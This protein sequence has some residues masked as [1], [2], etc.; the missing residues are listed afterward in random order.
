MRFAMSSVMGVARGEVGRVLVLVLVVGLR[1][2]YGCLR[3]RL[4]RTIPGD[5]NETLG[6][7][8]AF[9]ADAM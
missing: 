6:G 7:R 3:G 4:W 5:G 2:T 8:V 1:D 9:I